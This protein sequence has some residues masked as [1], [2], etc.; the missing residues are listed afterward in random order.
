MKFYYYSITNTKNEKVYIGITEDYERRIFK[1][2]LPLLRKNK[3]INYK[4]Q[5][6]W[7]TFGEENFKFEIIEERDFNSLEEA[8]QHEYDLILSSPKEKYNIAL[9]GQINPM[10]SL[11]I[12]NKMIHTKQSAVPNIF[13]LKEIEENVFRIIKI[14]NSQKEAARETKGH[15]RSIHTAIKLHRQYNEYYWVSENDIHIFEKEWRPARRK[16]SPTAEFSETGEILK[17]HYNSR[18]FELEYNL[19][20]GNISSSISQGN[21]SFGRTFKHITKEEYYSLKPIK[22][23]F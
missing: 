15:Q 17:V 1:E 11:E 7:N 21:K 23:V 9:G 10:Y 8:Y 16:F 20:R 4:L 2:H 13:Q 6:D 18:L 5:A 12:K 22:L 3:H 19:K 14:F